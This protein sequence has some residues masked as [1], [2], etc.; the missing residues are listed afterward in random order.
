MGM[1]QEHVFEAGS[2]LADSSRWP[3]GVMLGAG[4]LV[5][6]VPVGVAEESENRVRA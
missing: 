3:S 5:L 4:F 6:R 2:T 1:D